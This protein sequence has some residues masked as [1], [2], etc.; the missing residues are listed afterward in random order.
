MQNLKKYLENFDACFDSI[1]WAGKRRTGKAAWLACPRADWL[2]WL[3]GRIGID[4]N[5]IIFAACDIAESVLHFVP[6]N[7]DRP[8]K[9]IKAARSFVA[10]KA[11]IQEVRAAYD[12]AYAAAYA[13]ADAAAAAYADAAVA[14]D[15]AVRVADRAAAAAVADRAAAAADAYAAGN[16]VYDDRAAAY[17]KKQQELAAIVRKRIPFSLWQ[18]KLMK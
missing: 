7:E 14:A 4:N 9:A 2:L 11:T 1:E 17:V 13:A 10:G 15:Y 5:L 16:I 18:E 8:K 6:E 12:A 3:A